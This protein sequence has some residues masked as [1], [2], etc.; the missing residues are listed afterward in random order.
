MP[1]LLLRAVGAGVAYS[2]RIVLDFN[3]VSFSF[4]FRFNASISKKKLRGFKEILFVLLLMLLLLLPLVSPVSAI[5]A[6]DQELFCLSSFF[7]FLFFPVNYYVY[8][9]AVR[10]FNSV[11]VLKN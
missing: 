1:N 5:G 4:K 8:F 6:F 9:F 3:S 11:I 2:Y 10:K 7:L